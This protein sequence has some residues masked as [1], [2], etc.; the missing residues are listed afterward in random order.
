MKNKT[1]LI[2]AF[3]LAGTLAFLLLAITQGSLSLAFIG[4][5]FFILFLW[6]IRVAQNPFIQGK[7]F[8]NRTFSGGLLVSALSSGIGFGIPYLTPLLL[9]GVVDF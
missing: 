6:R 5:V 8:E 4:I 3:L 7:I 1:D 9:Q 2:V